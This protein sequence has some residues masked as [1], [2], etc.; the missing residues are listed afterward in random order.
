M[1]FKGPS[2]QVRLPENGI[3]EVL[4]WSVGIKKCLKKIYT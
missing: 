4:L 3:N 2:H 1:G